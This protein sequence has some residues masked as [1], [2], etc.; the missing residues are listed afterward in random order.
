MRRRLAMPNKISL[1]DCVSELMTLFGMGRFADLEQ[2]ARTVLP[3]F[4]NSPILCEL[5]GMAL[6]AQYRYR[7]ALVFFKRAVRGEPNDPQFWENLG[8]CQRQLNQFGPAENS[9]RRALALRPGWP[10]TLQALV[11]VLRA[12]GRHEDAQTTMDQLLAVDPGYAGRQMEE[13]EQ[14]LHRAIAAQPRNSAF[15]DDLGLLQRLKGDAVGAET[16]FRRAL[17]C[18]RSNLRA[19]VNLALLL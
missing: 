4:P 15:H 2:R 10:D 8:Q 17:D 1:Q 12:L 13:R 19:H 18:N 7:D 16:S 6:G 11:E 3:S 5:L 9:L 14:D